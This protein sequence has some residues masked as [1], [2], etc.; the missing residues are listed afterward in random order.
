MAF[1]FNP[2]TGNLDLVYDQADQIQYDNTSSGLTATDVQD[3]ID[4]TN[5]RIDTLPD[6]IVYKGTYNALTNTPAL[7]N[8]DVGK[9]GYLYQVNVAGT[10]NFGAGVISFDVG[11]KVVNN[12]TTWDKWDMTDAVTS[13]NGQ[14]GTVVL[15]TD[16]VTEGVSNL[17]FTVERA[18][19][20]TGAMATSSAKVS[21]TYNDGANTLTPDI[22]AGS[23]VNA[24]I[25]A[26]ANIDASK[27][28]TG[29][30][31]TT[32]FNY[33][34]G[35]TSAIQTQ[36]TGKANTTLNNLG[37]TAINANLL[38][39]ADGTRNI[40]SA[41]LRFSSLFGVV[42]T[43]SSPS[44]QFVPASAGGNG[45]LVDNAGVNVLSITGRSLR[46]SVNLAMID[47]MTFGTIGMNTNRLTAVA[48]PSSAQD[49][50]T[51]NYVD[52]ADALKAN[53]TLN[54]LGTTAI[55][56]SLLVNADATYNLGSATSRF[57]S[58]F[59]VVFTGASTSAQFV[60]ASA[61]G[62]G[63]LVDNAGTTTLS[64]TGRSLRSSSGT[65]MIDFPTAGTVGMNSNRLTSVTDPTA[66]QDAATKNYV[67]TTAAPTSSY[68]I[69]NLG[70]ATSVAANALTIALKQKDGTTDPA[71]GTGAVKLGMRSSTL[72]SGLYNQRSATAATS[73][74]ISSG[75]T[76]GQTNA[77]PA[78][79]YIYLIDNAGTPELAVSGSIFSE[80]RVI[81]TTAEG[82]GGAADLSSVMYSTTAR[83]NV[84]FRLVGKLVN[85]Q[86]TAGTWASAGTVLSVGNYG[87]LISANDMGIRYSGTTSSVSG[88]AAAVTYTTK[89]RDP[90]AAYSGSTFTVPSGE[91]G[92]YMI[93]GSV[94]TSWTNATAGSSSESIMIY[95]NGSE[96][97]RYFQYM[98]LSASGQ[99][100]IAV[101]DIVP[102]IAGDTIQIFASSNATSPT[103]AN[104]VNR[105]FIS[106]QKIGS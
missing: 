89:N 58:L 9:T 39:D 46:S 57:S 37:T 97:S 71:V 50:A 94:N 4:E 26:T 105:A 40:G 34:D 43:G 86:T 65:A 91:D 95:K 18:Q 15:T 16:N 59:G 64:I 52:T 24:D 38:P 2:I 96:Y 7:S 54:N 79:I 63:A 76:L 62:N 23:L 28:G 93:V 85:T 73:L 51:K 82:G 11:D 8:T 56:A 1:K 84:P 92:S 45:A 104:D 41:T 67:D 55:N 101:S 68:E 77:V 44:A 90:H 21:L 83:S 35:V 33:L 103:L 60:P 69:S 14:T 74:V 19:D 72:T 47:F 6:P 88:T 80:N 102:L 36:F 29:I 27:L 81:S 49:A 75:S 53:T 31:S 100:M 42:F 3:A 98:Q 22:V 70:L 12:G 61:G 30:V 17:Y 20:A 10:Q 13:V 25:S 99:D 5:V 87:T 78:T 106:I 32:E 48:D 66:A